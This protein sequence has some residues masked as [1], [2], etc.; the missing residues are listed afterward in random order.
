MSAYGASGNETIAAR[1]RR[2]FYGLRTEGSG[3]GREAT[4]IGVG[5]FIGC[6]PFYGFHLLLCWIVGTL[7]RL[8]RLKVYLAA[9]I[10]NPFMAPWLLFAELQA[11]AW[12]RHGAFQPI[13]VSAI[14]TAGFGAL[15]LDLLV[16][17]V[18]VG[19]V[20]AVIA[21]GATYGTLRASAHDAPFMEL[22]HKASDRYVSGSVTAWEFARGKMRGDPIYR[23]TLFDKLLPSAST[24]I[25]VGCG[26]GLMLALLAEARRALDRGEWPTTSP[27]PP[28]FDRLIGIEIRPRVAALADAALEG[29]AE[30]LR[31]DARALPS[32]QADAILLFVVLHLIE[33]SEQA[34]LLAALA[35]A[36][37]PGGVMLV[38]EADGSAGGVSRGPIR[39]LRQGARRRPMAAD[40][41]IPLQGGVARLFRQS[42]TGCGGSI[43]GRRHALRQ[44]AVSA[45]CETGRVWTHPPT[46]TTC[47]RARPS[48]SNVPPNHRPHSIVADGPGGAQ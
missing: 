38:R 18:L 5:V 23:A 35:A 32:R 20:L 4:A 12:F 45:Q 41:R 39:Q 48:R 3:A 8:N 15:G 1:F 10:S 26:Q 31:A 17:S 29:D 30:V 22:V 27:C 2:G 34:A 44:P 37:Q 40:V 7:F 24:L 46:R 13:S 42:R 47:V 28:R 33:V 25:D 36:L 6:L 9:N 43:D 14:R 11:G 21:G 19:S 16:G